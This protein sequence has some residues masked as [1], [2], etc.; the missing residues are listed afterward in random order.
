MPQLQHIP[1]YHTKVTRDAQ[2]LT[3][4]LWDTDI[5]QV[6]GNH[7]TLNTGSHNTMT[8]KNR[9]NQ[10]SNQYHLGFR[11][12]RGM[13][14]RWVV[15]FGDGV[16]YLFFENNRIE[17]TIAHSLDQGGDSEHTA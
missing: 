5:V 15:D 13:G 4:R 2:K 7:V 12:R 10:T 6:N 9:M 14:R 1:K 3:V 17:F 16:N 8:T 11:V